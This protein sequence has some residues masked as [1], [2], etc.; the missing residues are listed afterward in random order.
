MLLGVER[1]YGARV[2][3][4]W[5]QDNKDIATWPLPKEDDEQAEIVKIGK[6][7]KSCPSIGG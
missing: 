6:K 7:A 1:G 4:G 2:S 3:T 5:K